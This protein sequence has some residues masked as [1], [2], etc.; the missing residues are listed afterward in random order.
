MVQQCPE[1]LAELQ[2]VAHLNRMR[3]PDGQISD[4]DFLFA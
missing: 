3:F 2:Q 4:C 1:R